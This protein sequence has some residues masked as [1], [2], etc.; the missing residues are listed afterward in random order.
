MTQTSA[1]PIDQAPLHRPDEW[2]DDLLLRYPNPASMAKEKVPPV[3]AIT[4]VHRRIP[5]V[6]FTG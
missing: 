3:T 6:N 4:Q 1:A 2:E 5:F